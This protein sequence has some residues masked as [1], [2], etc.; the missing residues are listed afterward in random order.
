MDRISIDTV[1]DICIVFVTCIGIV[2]GISIV[3]GIGNGINIRINNKKSIGNG[4][5]F[6]TDN[7]FWVCIGNGINIAIT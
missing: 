2:I 3:I 5:V 4:T 1:I 6:S 7:G